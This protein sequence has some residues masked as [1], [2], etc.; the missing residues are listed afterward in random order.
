MNNDITTKSKEQL[1]QQL[2]EIVFN[3]I[4][5]KLLMD[6]SYST[7]DRKIKAAR[8]VN[9]TAIGFQSVPITSIPRYSLNG[10]SSDF[11]VKATLM[12]SIGHAVDMHSRFTSLDEKLDD[13]RQIHE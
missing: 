12:A 4:L 3:S 1:F 6:P 5:D 11:S 9:L 8:A 10:H 2:G 13:T 7:I